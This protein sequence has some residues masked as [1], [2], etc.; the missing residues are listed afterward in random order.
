MVG[1]NDTN[2][3]NEDEGVG[4]NVV[5]FDT[6]DD[7]YFGV[8]ATSA[9][10]KDKAGVDRTLLLPLLI[11]MTKMSVMILLPITLFGRMILLMPVLTMVLGPI[12][13]HMILLMAMIM[14]VRVKILL[15]LM[16]TLMATSTVMMVTMRM[17]FIA[18]K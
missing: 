1:D 16:L 2:D 10:S 4:V 18:T 9:V 3:V 13:L 8:N 6:V 7:E 11:L 5:A 12:L 17:I 15:L 14:H